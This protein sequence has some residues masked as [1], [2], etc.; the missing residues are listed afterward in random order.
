MSFKSFSTA[1]TDKS[2]DKSKA[3][4]AV[5]SPDAKPAVAAPATAPAPKS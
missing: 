3:A 2:D 5:A 1:Q 4:P